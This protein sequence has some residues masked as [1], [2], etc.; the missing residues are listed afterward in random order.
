MYYH[1]F[2]KAFVFLNLFLNYCRELLAH[3]YLTMLVQTPN[4]LFPGLPTKNHH[5]SCDAFRKTFHK[6]YLF[7]ENVRQFVLLI[8][9]LILTVPTMHFSLLPLLFRHYNLDHLIQ[10]IPVPYIYYL[11]D[12]VKQHLFLSV[13]LAT[14][15]FCEAISI[16]TIHELRSFVFY[17]KSDNTVPIAGLDQYTIK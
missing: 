17:V 16:N 8:A 12:L 13:C 5:K 11:L 10:D 1:S 4:C 15:Q 14:I 7:R 2:F 6:R 9:C 3:V